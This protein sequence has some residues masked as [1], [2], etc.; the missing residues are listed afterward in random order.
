MSRTADR[1]RLLTLLAETEGLSNARIKVELNLGDARYEKVR[2]ELID[3]GIAEK[4][5][6]RGGGLR[7]TKKGEKQVSPTDEAKSSVDKEQ[8]LYDPLV[9]AL[10]HEDPK[11]IAFDTASLRK[12]GKWQNPDVTQ[13]SVEVYPRLRRRRVLLTTFEVKQW[14]QWDVSGVFEAASHARFAHEGLV[15]LEWP[16]K[17][18]FSLSDPRLDNWVRE[19]RRFGIGFATLEKHYTHYRI[20]T[21]LEP[22]G[23]EPKDVDVEEWLDYALSRRDTAL[24]QFEKLMSESEKALRGE[25][26]AD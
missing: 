6:C 14:G 26:K 10:L 12:R 22:A 16:A 11:S 25:A 23:A 21:R 5:V 15:V 3:Q 18:P 9:K 24:A 1:D 17:E 19:C 8:D 4:Y 2:T 13:I 20:H 7:L